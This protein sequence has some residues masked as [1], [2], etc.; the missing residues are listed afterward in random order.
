MGDEF[1]NSII[2]QV[3]ELRDYVELK[4]VLLSKSDEWKKMFVYC[5]D[6]DFSKE[7]FVECIIM[8]LNTDNE[9]LFETCLDSLNT[10]LNAENIEVFTS[11]KIYSLV[12]ERVKKKN[13]YMKPIVESFIKKVSDMT[14]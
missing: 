14:K 13:R 8:L 10:I 12:L 6:N 1:D 11:S 9:E 2:K 3:K 4:N 7:I 5:I